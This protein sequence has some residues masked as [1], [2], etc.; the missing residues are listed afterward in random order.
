MREGPRRNL[1]RLVREVVEDAAAN[2]A[3]WIEP[4]LN[5]LTYE[6]NSDAALDLLDEVIDEG[7]RTSARLGV[8]FGILMF[9][10]RNAD[11]S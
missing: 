3:V 9:A 7:R 11:P 2:G 4:H 6:D 1:L 8:G 10:R 5:P